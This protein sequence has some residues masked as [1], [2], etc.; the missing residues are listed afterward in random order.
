MRLTKKDYQCEKNLINFL[1]YNK[2][3]RK[4][5][6][7]IKLNY[8]GFFKILNMFLDIFSGFFKRLTN[9]ILMFTLKEAAFKKLSFLYL[10]CL[11]KN[12]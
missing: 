9:E 10:H 2:T 6:L 3:S 4:I 11:D 1:L 7:K 12:C 5:N 8:D